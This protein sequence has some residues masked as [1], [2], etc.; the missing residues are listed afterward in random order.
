M[1]ILP[2]EIYQQ[3]HQD[4]QLD[5]QEENLDMDELLRIITK[6]V[7]QL[8]DQD[9]NLLFSYLYRL[10]VLEK[11]LKIALSGVTG[12]NPIDFMAELILQRQKD[13]VET[14]K[15]YKQ[16]PIEGWEW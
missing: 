10:D 15:K 13:R 14:K 1:D 6:R 16:K 9:P 5:S 12:K 11:D 3:V 7:E 8:L 4:I 2:I